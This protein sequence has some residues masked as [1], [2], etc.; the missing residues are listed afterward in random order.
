MGRV[1]L[2]VVDG[3]SIISYASRWQKYYTF[4]RQMIKVVFLLPTDG[5]SKASSAYRFVKVLLL[6][7]KD[8][9]RTLSSD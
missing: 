1:K 2:P 3:K 7:P 6:L 4:C 5:K 9:K 8:W